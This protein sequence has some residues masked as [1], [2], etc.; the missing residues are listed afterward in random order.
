MQRAA[1]RTTVLV[2]ISAFIALSALSREVMQPKRGEPLISSGETRSGTPLPSIAIAAIDTVVHAFFDFE[3]GLGGPD[4]Q[5]WTTVDLSVDPQDGVF[6]HIDDFAGLA[7]YAPLDGSRSLWCGARPDPDSLCWYGTLPGYG[8]NWLQGFESRSFAVSGDVTVRFQIGYDLEAGFDFAYFEYWS[9]SGVWREAA[10][11]SGLG[12]GTW[13][14]TIPDDSLGGYTAFRFFVETDEFYSDEDGMYDS[15]GAIVVDSLLI[16]DG[17]GTVDFQDFESETPGDLVTADGDWTA[18]IYDVTPF[19]DY[20]ALLDG[21]TVLQENPVTYNDT[22]LWGFFNGSSDVYGCGSHPEQAAVPFGREPFDENDF[23]HNAIRSPMIDLTRSISGGYVPPGTGTV[24]LEFDVYR[25]LPRDNL[26]YFDIYWRFLVDGCETLWRSD[27]YVQYGVEPFDW[28]VFSFTFPVE[29]GATHVQVELVARD[30]C[31]FWCGSLGTGACHTHAPLFDNVRVSRAAE[32]ILVTNTDDSG[33]G[34]LRQAILDANAAPD[35]SVIAFDIPGTGPHTIQPL[36]LLPTIT[37]TVVI[38]GYSQHGAAVNTNPSGS[39]G[40]AV[41]MIEIDGTLVGAGT[42]NHGLSVMAD[43]CLIRG[44]AINRFGGCGILIDSGARNTIAGNHI[45]TDA[46]GMI[47]RGNGDRGVYIIHGP[48]NTIGGTAPEDRNVISGNGGVGVASH[49]QFSS[50]NEILGNFVGV[51]ATGAGALGNGGGGVFILHAPDNVIG[52]TA[53]GARNV[54]SANAVYGVYV[55]GLWG[56]NARIEGNYIGTDL[57]GTVALGNTQGLGL[58]NAPNTVIG[59]SAPGAGNVIASSGYVGLSLQGADTE[60]AVVMGNLI[61]TDVSGTLPRGNRF[62]VSMHTASGNTIGGAGPGE[63]NVI[64]NSQLYGVGID[65]GTDNEVIGNSIHSNGGLGI[66]LDTDGVT[67]NDPLGDPDTGPNGLQNYPL[68]VLAAASNDSIRVQGTFESAFDAGFEIEF[69]ASPSCDPSGYG[70]GEIYLGSALVTTNGSGDALIDVTL[71]GPIPG[72]Y[73]IT[74]TARDTAG[75]GTSEFSNCIEYYNTPPGAG[76]GVIPV[77]LATGET[78]VELTFDAVTGYGSTFLQIEAS[79][80]EVPGTFVVGDP[81]TF[82]SLSTTAPYTDSIT[83]CF[84][85]D[86]AAVPGDESDL[87]ILHFDTTLVPDDWVDIT[88]SLDTLEN[89]I[90]GRTATLSPFILAVPNPDTGVDDDVPAA[91]ET[92]ALHQNIPNPFNP[93]TTIRYDVPA[94]GAEVRVAVYDVAGRLVA[95][96][97]DGYQPAGRREVAWNGRG[98]TGAPVAAGVYFCRMTAGEWAESRKMV[99]LR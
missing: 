9:V 72:G 18:V 59:G 77:D 82:Y 78:P 4:P 89:V 71:P 23:L 26:V 75:G 32:F 34:S 44:L 97:V 90:C 58:Y 76:V 12:S 80:P 64:A 56:K 28:E 33:P 40:N 6:F 49:A 14:A 29:A 43:D 22:H 68:L 48:D 73:G 95:V 7:G 1:G 47:D 39:A 81:A 66:D 79:G 96:L 19:G 61:G 50:N 98:S 53:P 38:E 92:F 54:I 41:L 11:F 74:S 84:A 45:G 88:S 10:S 46:T 13:Q 5:G 17:G 31:W 20:G 83:V 52:G 85:Y 70:E 24:L 25:D 91:P 51:D 21:S 99:L 55:T 94:G 67:A 63:G 60:G 65:V 15:N 36:T 62:G 16:T 87:V 93:S 35:T 57:T 86:E 2:F 37:E 42:A 3:D 8:L 69:F 27:I 30:M